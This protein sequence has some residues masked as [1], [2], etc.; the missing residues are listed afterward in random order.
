MKELIHMAAIAACTESG[1][2]GK[3]NGIPWH[4]PDD[5]KRFK[6]LTGSSPMIMGRKTYESLPGVLPNRPHIVISRSPGDDDRVV[7]TD[8]I[9]EAIDMA[10]LYCSKNGLE[11][12]FVIGGAEIYKQM[13]DQCSLLYLTLVKEDWTGDTF[14][15]LDMID[16]KW[17]IIGKDDHPDCTFTFWYNSDIVKEDNTI[18]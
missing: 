17:E 14:F 7:Y 10:R 18:H 15:P 5:F 3:D 11:R 12:F 4:I 2:L 9:N 16:N 13:I 8:D 1:V 6:Q